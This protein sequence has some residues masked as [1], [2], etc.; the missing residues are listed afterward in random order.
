MLKLDT[1]LRSIVD[2][3]LHADDDF[4]GLLYGTKEKRSLATKDKRVSTSLNRRERSRKRK[5]WWWS[6]AGWSGAKICLP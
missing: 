4:H 5:K 2:N 1:N 3:A 6:Q